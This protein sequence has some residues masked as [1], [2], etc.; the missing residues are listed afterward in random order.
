MVPVYQ[1]KLSKKQI[2]QKAQWY[3][4][5][6][7]FDKHHHT[8]RNDTPSNRAVKIVDPELIELLDETPA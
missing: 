8:L 2:K 1:P 4:N 6:R 7:A 3:K 5:H